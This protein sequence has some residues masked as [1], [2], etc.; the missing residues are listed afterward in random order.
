MFPLSRSAEQSVKTAASRRPSQTNVVDSGEVQ[1]TVAASHLDAAKDAADCGPQTD[2]TMDAIEQLRQD[3]RIEMSLEIEKEVVKMSKTM[4]QEIVDMVTAMLPKASNANGDAT[5]SSRHQETWKSAPLRRKGESLPEINPQPVDTCIT[6]IVDAMI[7]FKLCFPISY[8][9]AV[10]YNQEQN[11]A[12]FLFAAPPFVRTCFLKIFLF[13]SSTVTS[14][15]TMFTL[16]LYHNLFLAYP[17]VC[18]QFVCNLS[19][20]RLTSPSYFELSFQELKRKT[21]I[22]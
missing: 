7:S 8:G 12:T 5:T 19:V 9:I 3:M 11:M 20:L 16:L 14:I 2:N 4:R 17:S 18:Y 15:P 6:G 22:F 13:H 1:V 21:M 10:K